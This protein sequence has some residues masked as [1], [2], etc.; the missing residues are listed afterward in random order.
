[1]GGER[2]VTI[3]GTPF[4]QLTHSQ[5]YKEALGDR[6]D[7][8][9][10]FSRD[11]PEKVY[12]QNK[13]R[14]NAREINDLLQQKKAFFYVCGDAANMA[15]EVNSLLIKII[16]EQRGVPEQKAE[17]VVKTMRATNQYQEDVWS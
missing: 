6:F 16:A 8:H 10:A 11:G 2:D 14:D 17:E 9:V 13:I 12:V 7:M 15:R 3:A 4:H 5:T 1:M